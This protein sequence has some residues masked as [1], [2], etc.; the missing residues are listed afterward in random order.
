MPGTRRSVPLAL[1]LALGASGCGL[2]SHDRQDPPN[3][4]VITGEQIER[5]GAT[6]AWDALRRLGTHLTLTES[7]IGQAQSIRHRGNSSVNLSNAPTVLVDGI[8]HPPSSLQEVPANRIVEI[9]I[10]G[11]VAGTS[12]YGTGSGNGVIVVTTR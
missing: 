8:R 10:L 12:R 6:N 9:R 4:R 7:G 5:S 11:G 3:G 1:L 2:L